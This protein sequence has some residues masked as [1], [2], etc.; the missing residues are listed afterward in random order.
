MRGNRLHYCDLCEREWTHVDKFGCRNLV[1][2]CPK[3]SDMVRE[4]FNEVGEYWEYTDPLVE[5]VLKVREGGVDG[6][7][8]TI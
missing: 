7:K 5:F 1:D 4:F 3:C 6:A 8:K 2:T